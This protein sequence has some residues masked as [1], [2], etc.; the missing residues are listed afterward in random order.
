MLADDFPLVGDDLPFAAGKPLD[1]RYG[2]PAVDLGPAFARRARQRLREVGG[3]DISVL[4]VLDRADDPFDVAERPDGLDL[5][6]SEELHRDADRLRD[7]GVVIVLVHPVAGARKTDVR[8]LAKADVEPRL[9]FQRPVERNGIFVNLPDRIAEVEQRQQARR[10]PGRARGQFLALD[11]NAI[12]PAF[13]GEVIERRDA[14]HAP[15]DDHRPRM[16]S[17]VDT[18]ASQPP[19]LFRREARTPI[20]RKRASRL[21]PHRP[22]R[23]R[24]EDRSPHQ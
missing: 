23:T 13:P 19:S 16:R 1:C 14:D 7:A 21:A 15:A 18:H 24:R 10:M 2:S 12:G 11:E 8:H 4:G 20:G 3:L 17:H 6:G 5:G 9:L 22:L